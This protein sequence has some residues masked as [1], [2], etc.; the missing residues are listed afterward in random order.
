MILRYNVNK[1]GYTVRRFLSEENFPDNVFKEIRSGNGQYLVNDQIVDDHFIIHNN[2]LLEVV[3]PSSTQGDNIV[4]VQGDLDI[5]YED[6]YFLI[7]NKKPN[8]ATLPTK[9][10]FTNSLAN[11]VMS[12]YKRKGIVAN[13]HFISRLDAPT[14]GI[15]MLAKNSYVTYL[16]QNTLIAKHY[17]LET[18]NIVTPSEGI[19]QNKIEKDPNSAIKR[20]IVEGVPNSKT[21]YKTMYTKNNHSFIDALLCTGKTHQLRLHFSNMGYPIIGDELYGEA[22]TDRIL[23]LHSY[24]LEFIHPITKK[25][26]VIESYP[27]WFNKDEL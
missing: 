26:V 18:S 13:I 22:T 11:H 14:S 25:E 8:L 10:Y 1:E 9:G 15:I 3:L 20:M 21:V 23:H 24:Y 7:I 17:I 6:A 2:D 27:D 19:I 16:M 4:S 5:L 12:Y